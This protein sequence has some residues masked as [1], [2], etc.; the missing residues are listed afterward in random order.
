MLASNNNLQIISISISFFPTSYFLLFFSSKARDI[1][2]IIK[3]PEPM[4]VVQKSIL[5]SLNYSIRRP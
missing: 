5:K 3:T 2:S 1:I 4:I